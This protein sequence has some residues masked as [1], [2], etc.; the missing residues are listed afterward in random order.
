MSSSTPPAPPPG[1]G[2]GSTPCWPRRPSS[3]RS[4]TCCGSSN[5]DGQFEYRLWEPFVTPEY[6]RALLVDGLLVTVTMAVFAIIGAVIFGFVFGVAKMSDHAFIRWPAWVVVEF[7]RA[8]PVLLLMI[9]VFFAWF[10]SRGGG[11]LWID[12]RGG[13]LTVVIALACYNGAVLAEVVRAG[14]N[15]VPKGQAEA[16]YAVGMSKSQV[17]RIILLPQAVKVMLPAMI[18]QMVVALK[19]TSLGFAVAA[20]GLTKVGQQIYKEFHNQVQAA[21]VMAVLY[22]GLNLLLTA[23]ATWVQRRYVGENKIDVVAAAAGIDAESRAS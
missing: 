11:F 7:F 20:P 3:P 23:L 21:I 15:A 19:D 6:I 9:F 8:M 10:V 13:F 12:D 1:A 16:A 22:V 4:P 18:S 17:M 14:V 5:D 2:T